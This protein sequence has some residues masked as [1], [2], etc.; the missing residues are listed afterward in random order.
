VE[1]LGV[2]GERPGGQW[3]GLAEEWLGPRTILAL[4]I[5]LLFVGVFV[6]MILNI[7]TQD[8]VTWTRLVFLYGAA[9]ALAFTVVGLVFG[10]T[11][12]RQQL[13]NLERQLELADLRLVAA[14]RA[15]ERAEGTAAAGRAL[16]T[17]ISV[18]AVTVTPKPCSDLMT[19]LSA[20]ARRLL[21]D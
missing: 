18:A 21:P 7:E 2:A 20:E 17:A 10:L 12:S 15:L 11:V 19:T 16:A 4:L 8:E 13:R 9:A 3:Q 1:Q 14:Q 5:L 6:V